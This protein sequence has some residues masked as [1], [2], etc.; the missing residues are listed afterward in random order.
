MAE[1]YKEKEAAPFIE[2]ATALETLAQQKNGIPHHV[3]N[4]RFHEQEASIVANAGVSGAVT[5]ATNMA[6]RG[7]DI[8]LG[9]N[10]DMRLRAE[11]GDKKK[12]G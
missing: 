11:I 7:T 5:I 6:G 8:Q 9:G 4:A 12:R 10:F 2:D 1:T 3:L